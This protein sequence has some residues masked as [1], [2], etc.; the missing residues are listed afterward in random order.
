MPIG[1]E[2]G[3][4]FLFAE[5]SVFTR[6]WAKVEEQDMTTKEDVMKDFERRQIGAGPGE[7]EIQGNAKGDG[8]G[9]ECQ[10]FKECGARIVKGVDKQEQSTGGRQV[11]QSV[12]IDRKNHCA[13]EVVHHVVGE[14]NPSVVSSNGSG[15]KGVK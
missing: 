14:V 2:G 11:G 3:D 13:E 1:H 4:D 8:P 6:W 5:G 10:D 12:W 15:L 7:V 9:M